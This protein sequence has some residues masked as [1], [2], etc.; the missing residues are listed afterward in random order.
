MVNILKDIY[1]DMNLANILGFKG[2]TALMLFHDLPRFSVDLD[3]NLLDT[4]L[5]DMVYSKVRK[6]ILK[7][8]KID[9]EAK[10]F[11]GPLFV[12]DYGVGER[13]LKVEISN[14]KPIA[15]Y[16]TQNY[17]GINIKLMTLPDMFS[18]KLCALLDR[19]ELVSRD[20][21]DTWFLLSKQT[22]LHSEIIETRMNKPLP[23][24]LQNCIN[25]IEQIKPTQLL[26]GLGELINPE[27]KFFA[28]NKLKNEVLTLLRFYKEEATQKMIKGK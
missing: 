20:I 2:G 26:D 11:F 16:E 8:G 28:K 4:D 13:K 5:E 18:H 3:F 10:K 12:L 14:R 27:L 21:F 6:I 7:Y 1:S 17:L 22:P 23:E 19:N 25:S 9:D 24:Y 15:V